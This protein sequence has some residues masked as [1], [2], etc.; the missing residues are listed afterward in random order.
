MIALN[1]LAETQEDLDFIEEQLLAI[2]GAD[3]DTSRQKVTLEMLTQQAAAWLVSI[4]SK[5]LRDEQ[6]ARNQNGS[7]NGRDLVQWAVDRAVV[8]AKKD[9]LRD[10]DNV[11]SAV[12]RQHEARAIKLEEEAKSLQDK[13]VERAEVLE[14]FKTMA[15]EVRRELESIPR[16]MA[17][18]FP[19][20]WREAQVKE[21]KNE[22]DQ[23]LRR[24]ESKGKSLQ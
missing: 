12:E 3:R 8:K 11:K 15:A 20:R 5:H 1:D 19:E 18:D 23:V 2:E 16:A 4:S 10:T 24:L 9:W 21:L 22:I 17:S 13:Y 6:A 14:E 7:Y